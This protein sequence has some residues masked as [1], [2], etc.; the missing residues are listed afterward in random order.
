MMRD[1]HIYGNPPP[2]DYCVYCQ[3]PLMVIELPQ[4]LGT[5]VLGNREKKKFFLCAPICSKAPACVFPLE[6]LTY[7]ES[8]VFT[9]CYKHTHSV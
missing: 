3:S 6:R 8:W 4:E 2:F 7:Y 1:Y 9:G 5:Y